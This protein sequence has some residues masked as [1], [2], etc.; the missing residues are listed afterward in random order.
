MISRKSDIPQSQLDGWLDSV[1]TQFPNYRLDADRG[2][3]MII[4]ALDGTFNSS[5]AWEIHIEHD[6][7]ILRGAIITYIKEFIYNPHCLGVLPCSRKKGV[8]TALMSHV[9]DQAHAVA[10]P[11]VLGAVLPGAASLVKRLGFR[12]AY[13]PNGSELHKWSTLPQHRDDR[14]PGEQYET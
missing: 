12:K 6:A 3:F 10:K 13:L 1:K 11:V 4:S 8:A 5:N 7:G 9:M 2:P 14:I